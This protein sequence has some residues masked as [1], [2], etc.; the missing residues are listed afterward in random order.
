MAFLKLN[1]AGAGET[2]PL[3]DGQITYLTERSGRL[4]EVK[5][6]SAAEGALVRIRN[7]WVI[8]DFSGYK[9]SVNG[10]RVADCKQ[11]HEGDQIQFGS[12]AAQ[13]SQKIRRE[14]I[15]KGS[16]LLDPR[17][18]CFFDLE[19]FKIGASVVYC[20]VCDTPYHADCWEAAK[21]SCD[22]CGYHAFQKSS[23]A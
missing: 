14:T 7:N 5:E 15:Q 16:P 17:R 20:P 1:A 13:L 8:L 3:A 22:Q 21:Q 12:V 10:L 23:Q 9:L 18:E 11:V 2:V 6:R 4:L 19:R